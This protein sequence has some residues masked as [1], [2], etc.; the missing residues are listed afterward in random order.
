M[1]L[2]ELGQ[3]RHCSPSVVYNL[4]GLGCLDVVQ[5]ICRASLFLSMGL[6]HQVGSM[7]K[8]FV[9]VYNAIFTV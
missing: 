9:D 7:S 5:P 1:L 6:S 8:S 2:V 4:L 3:W